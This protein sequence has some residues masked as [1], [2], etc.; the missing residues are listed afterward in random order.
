MLSVTL[1]DGSDVVDVPVGSRRS[2]RG[3][4]MGSNG[5]HDNG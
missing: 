4:V 3:S 2:S 1:Y 5:R